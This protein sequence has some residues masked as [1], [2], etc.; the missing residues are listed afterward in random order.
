M[1]SGLDA[2]DSAAAFLIDFNLA[3]VPAA[4]GLEATPA[5]AAAMYGVT[6]EQFSSYTG[7]VAAEVEA[8]A[9]R[10]LED[11]T[12]AAAVDAFPVASGARL[13]FVGDSITIYRR[14][15][16][17][18]LETML[19]L[20]RPADQ[21]AVVNGGRSG[22]TSSHGIE[23]TYVEFLGVDPDLV[24]VSFG[25]NDCKR[26]GG[27]DR[28]RGQ[29]L[30]DPGAY[31]ENLAG[32]VDAFRQYTAARV[33]VL[34]PTPVITDLTAANPDFRAGRV[35][36]E[37]ADLLACNDIARE[38]AGDRGLTFVDQVQA[39][40]RAPSPDLYL[41]DGLHPGPAGHEVMLR[42]LLRGVDAGTPGSR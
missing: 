15:Y 42:A 19:K 7:A 31:R 2:V 26:F 6:L 23:L 12:L 39:L 37:M 25:G 33:V 17:R 16:A 29:L 40:G 5:A 36:W 20:R 30:V 14:S 10:L 24:T 1:T 41:A 27:D 9:R 34:G 35:H 3:D 13:L 18:L 8:E 11:A 4:V 32:I 21:I 28:G 22:F 38:I